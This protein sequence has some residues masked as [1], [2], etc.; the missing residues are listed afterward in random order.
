MDELR[1]WIS[2]AQ[3]ARETCQN[4]PEFDLLIDYQKRRLAKLEE[5][6]EEEGSVSSGQGYHAEKNAQPWQEFHRQRY[7][8]SRRPR[9]TAGKLVYHRSEI[10]PAVGIAAFLPV[11]Y[12]YKFSAQTNSG[13]P[14]NA[15]K[16]CR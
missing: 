10:W 14:P 5:K 1:E 2:A 8:H 11:K 9:A 15:L 6:L 13:Q 7:S 12:P 3:A 16:G 4:K